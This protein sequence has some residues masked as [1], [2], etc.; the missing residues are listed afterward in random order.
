MLDPDSLRIINLRQEYYE[1]D[2]DLELYQDYHGKLIF[3]EVNEGV[4]LLISKDHINEKNPI[5]YFE[6]K[7]ADSLEE[8]L[9]QFD[10]ESNF[11]EWSRIKL[12]N[13]D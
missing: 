4:Y 12:L 13:F 6:E 10:R 1:F 8:F 9:I 3:F 2:P 7:I 5:Y 11:F